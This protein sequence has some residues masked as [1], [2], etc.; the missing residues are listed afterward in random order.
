MSRIILALLVAAIVGTGTAYASGSDSHFA[1]SA[2]FTVDPVTCKLSPPESGDGA[3]TTL[4]TLK[5]FVLREDEIHDRIMRCLRLRH[6]VYKRVSVTARTT[7]V[8]ATC[9]QVHNRLVQ[10]RPSHVVGGGYSGGEAAASYP[11]SSQSWTV[12]RAHDNHGALTAYA[13]C[14]SVVG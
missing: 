13:V 8:V 11:S 10:N 5:R 1:V 2:R 12:T 6:T 3:G 9:P 14:A 7:D 4:A